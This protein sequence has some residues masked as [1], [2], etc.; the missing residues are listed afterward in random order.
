[1]YAMTNE[2]YSDFNLAQLATLEITKWSDYRCG[3][4]VTS[5]VGNVMTFENMYRQDTGLGKWLINGV[6]ITTGQSVKTG[7]QYNGK[8]EHVIHFERNTQ[9][10][11]ETKRYITIPTNLDFTKLNVTKFER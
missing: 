6:Y 11:I 5:A 4:K 8:D 1:M 3:V 10:E 9:F 2:A 7:R